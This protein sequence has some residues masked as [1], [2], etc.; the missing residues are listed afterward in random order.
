M[1]KI[2]RIFL[3]IS[4]IF[5]VITFMIDHDP[6]NIKTSIVKWLELFGVNE[7]NIP[8]FLYSVH[9]TEHIAFFYYIHKIIIVILIFIF[10]KFIY[11]KVRNYRALHY[12]Y[13]WSLKLT[14]S[15]KD[16]KKFVFISLHDGIAKI[17]EQLDV[18]QLYKDYKFYDHTIYPYLKYKQCSSLELFVIFTFILE[19]KLIL[20]AH[21]I[22]DSGHNRIN[23]THLSLQQIPKDFFRT[24]CD[25]YNENCWMANYSTICNGRYQ[26]TNVSMQLKELD[27]FIK[28]HK[29]TNILHSKHI[30]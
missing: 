3:T 8:S 6:Q 14:P 29:S 26:Y 2:Y 23:T 17:V 10:T 30:T 22:I 20:Y 4:I 7:K 15:K 25:I 12:L 18:K 13:Y 5:S 9:N 16:A 24:S 21:K 19:E 28:E 27:H 11:N 1:S